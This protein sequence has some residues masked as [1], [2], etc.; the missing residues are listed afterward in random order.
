MAEKMRSTAVGAGNTA[1]DALD[2]EQETTSRA[3]E[4]V[5]DAQLESIRT[6]GAAPKGDAGGPVGPG[7]R[8]E[9][10]LASPILGA[11]PAG[12]RRAQHPYSERPRGDLKQNEAG[13][14]SRLDEQASDETRAT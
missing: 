1:G 3:A 14:G 2:E 6:T 9:S 5:E 13:I 11:R 7:G 8:E 12:T 10:D 4:A